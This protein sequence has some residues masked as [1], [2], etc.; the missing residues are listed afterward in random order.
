MH[1]TSANNVEGANTQNQRESRLGDSMG[2]NQN[3]QIRKTALVQNTS[4]KQAARSNCTTSDL[5]IPLLSVRVII[6]W[7]NIIAK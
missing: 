4:T 1:L 2:K 7:Q 6:R 3:L 5:G